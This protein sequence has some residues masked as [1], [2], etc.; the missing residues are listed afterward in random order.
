[1]NVERDDAGFRDANERI[2]TMAEDLRKA[3]LVR[4]R[5]DGLNKLMGSYPEGHDMRERLVELHIERA[6]EGVEE[7]IRVLMDAIQHPRG[8]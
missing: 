6:L 7:D 3:E 8:T 1:V 2:E 5:L 4:D